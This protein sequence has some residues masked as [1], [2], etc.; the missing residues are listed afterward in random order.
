MRIGEKGFANCGL[1][2]LEGLSPEIIALGAGCFFG[3]TQLSSLGGEDGQGGYYGLV[4][5]PYLENLPD[6]CFQGC[7]GL[8]SLEGCG[9]YI[10]SFGKYCFA[11]TGLKNLSGISSS[12]M[13]IGEWCFSSCSALERLGE[14]SH[15]IGV[16]S[17][18]AHCFEGCGLGYGYAGFPEVN[19]LGAYCFANTQLA[20]LSGFPT[21]LHTIGEGCFA[22]CSSLENILGLSKMSGLTSLPKGCFENCTKLKT[23]DGIQN[24]TGLTSL[25]ENCFSGCTNLELVVAPRSGG[26]SEFEVDSDGTF[27]GV[28][29]PSNIRSIAKGCFSGCHLPF[30]IAL[31][32]TSADD[33]TN[34]S[35]DAL[36]TDPWYYR[37]YVYCPRIVQGV[38]EGMIGPYHIN[39]IPYDSIAT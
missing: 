5:C 3:C 14:A 12:L 37:T 23:I 27:Y 28:V 8:Q 33:V 25:P 34:L 39:F 1:E 17:L 38:Y 10:T 26:P 18:P 29:V 16:T 21:Y 36:P 13:T 31:S 24:A 11:Q 30:H 6:N 9:D 20:D 4:G 35:W 2:S 32:G 19:T 7:T 15:C 22:G